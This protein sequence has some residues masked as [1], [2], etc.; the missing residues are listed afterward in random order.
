M[1]TE[2]LTDE[3]LQQLAKQFI[4]EH[5]QEIIRDRDWW[6]GIE[7]Y[8][9]NV[10]SPEEDGWFNINVYK[11]DPVTGMDNYEW[12]IDLPRIYLGDETNRA[13]L[14]QCASQLGYEI[15]DEDCAD[16]MKDSPKGE[17]VWTATTDWLNTWE[18][19][20]DFDSPKYDNVYDDWQDVQLME[21]AA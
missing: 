8:S 4:A 2:E 20:A 19:C 18:T 13:Y 14:K 10:H 12:M 3:Q 15:S 17:T 6:W 9:F 21:K 7:G 11:V 16:I 5:I 1:T